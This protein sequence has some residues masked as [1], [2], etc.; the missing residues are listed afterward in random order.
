[1]GACSDKYVSRDKAVAI[2]MEAIAMADD[3]ELQDILNAACGGE[4]PT[5]EVP[6]YCL[7]YFRIGYSSDL[8]DDDE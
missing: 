2:L 3:C 5:V 4:S 8:D 1:M 6:G 7:K